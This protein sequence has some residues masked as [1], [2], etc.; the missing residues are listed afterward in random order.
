[1]IVSDTMSLIYSL[2]EWNGDVH[3]HSEDTEATDGKMIM[4]L[5]T[6]MKLMLLITIVIFRIMMMAITLL[7]E[8]LLKNNKQNAGVKV[9]DSRYQRIVALDIAR[10]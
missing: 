7:M 9:R 5:I 3:Y 4:R 6:I 8:T 1:M 10:G 2:K